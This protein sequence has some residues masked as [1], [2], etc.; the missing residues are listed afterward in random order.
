[1]L[2]RCILAVILLVSVGVCNSYAQDIVESDAVEQSADKQD[3]VSQDSAAPDNT[4]LQSSA[5]QDMQNDV[6]FFQF[7]NKDGGIDPNPYVDAGVAYYD[8]DQASAYSLGIQGGMSLMSKLQLDCEINLVNWD[9]DYG[10]QEAGMSDLLVSVRYL[11]LSPGEAEFAQDFTS[12]M[13]VT[14][15][16]YV[17]LPIG[18]EEIEQ[19]N[20]GLGVF[21]AARYPLEMGLVLAANVGFDYI[22]TDNWSSTSDDYELSLSL[23]IGAI[24][25]LNEQLSIVGELHKKTEIDYLLLSGGVDYQ[26]DFG[27]HIRGAIGR[28]FTDTVYGIGATDF[29]FTARFMY[30]F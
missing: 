22:E 24:Y 19:G 13:Q 26:L 2:H 10:Q 5:S 11:V 23:G 21:S 27:G 25:P 4:M 30:P 17:I 28:G 1:M 3:T 29:M 6:H 15:G 12:G 14:A 7:F 8:Y 20:L 18:S 9:P 16:G